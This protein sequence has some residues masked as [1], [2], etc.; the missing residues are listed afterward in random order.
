MNRRQQ[1]EAKFYELQKLPLFAAKDWSNW[2]LQLKTD[3]APRY[4]GVCMIDQQKILIHQ[5]RGVPLSEQL[6]TLV[7]EMS[8]AV[9]GHGG[10]GP[11]FHRTIL[12]AS[13]EA[14]IITRAQAIELNGMEP[15]EVER[16]LNKAW[17]RVLQEQ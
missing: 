13:Y 12:R 10:H 15:I 4:E 3:M 17:K 6:E 16:R 8:H 5:R 1:L 11:E 7:H 14:G 2:E 9:L